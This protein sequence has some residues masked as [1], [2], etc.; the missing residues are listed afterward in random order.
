MKRAFIYL[1]IIIIIIIIIEKI[2]NSGPHAEFWKTECEYQE[3]YK[4]ECK[5]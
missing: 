4:T 2:M 1:F 3:F 5:S